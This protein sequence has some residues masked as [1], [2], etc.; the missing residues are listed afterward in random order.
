M[1]AKGGSGQTLR[2]VVVDGFSVIDTV[3]QIGSVL[4]ILLS[5]LLIHRLTIAREHRKELQSAVSEFKDQFVKVITDLTSSE[6]NPT[7]L[8]TT[9]FHGH[10]EAAIKLLGKL[11]KRKARKFSRAWAEYQAFYDQKASLGVLG[12]FAAEITDP[13]RTHD[14]QYIYEVNA[15]HRKEAIAAIRSVLRAADL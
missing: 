13:S 8:V 7:L 14:P 2:A 11:P 4:G 1:R 5:V 9:N 6:A 12:S 10:K 15:M 3:I